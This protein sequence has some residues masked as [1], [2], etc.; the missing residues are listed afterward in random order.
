MTI[1]IDNPADHVAEAV[2]LT[3]EGE[4]HLRYMHGRADHATAYA[5]LAQ[6]HA[7][8]AAR[9]EPAGHPVTPYREALAELRAT[10]ASAREGALFSADGTT[11]S[12]DRRL[13]DA[14]VYLAAG[15]PR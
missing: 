8:L 14:V 1:P 3:K 11:V 13:W 5:R 15:E 6:V 12:M 9:G 10:I 7:T 4:E 2:R